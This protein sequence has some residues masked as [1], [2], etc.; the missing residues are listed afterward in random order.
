MKRNR[1]NN[2]TLKQLFLAVPASAL[3]LGSSQ[4]QT[5]VGINFAGGA[6]AAYASYN[7]MLYAQYFS[8]FPVTA[9]AFG[10]SPTNWTTTTGSSVGIPYN[11]GASGTVIAGPAASLTVNWT[12]VDCWG[13]DTGLTD[14][15]TNASG[16][17]VPPPGNDQVTWGILDNQGWTI[18][19]S[20]LNATFPNGYVIQC[21]GAGKVTGTSLVNFSDNSGYAASLGFDPLYTVDNQAIGLQT[22]TP[23]LTSDPITFSSDSRSM[24]DGNCAVAGFVVTDVPVVTLTSPA[25]TLI[26]PGAPFVLS[27]TAIGIGNLSYQWQQA[28]TNIP[29]ATSANYTNSSGAPSVA[30]DYQVVVTSSSFP[31]SPATGAVVVVTLH[32]AATVTWD[33]NTM[34]SGT[35]P[36][37]GSGTWS[38]TDT[39]WWNGSEDTY[40][41]VNDSAVFGAGGTGAYTVTLG[42]SVTA[43]AVTFNSGN[44]T[45]TNTSG[46]TLNL[47]G[48]QE[49]TANVGA[50]IAAPL[51]TGT[52][53]FLKA[54]AGALVISS[55]GLTCGQTFVNAGT[56][57]VLAKSGG[58]SPY[59]VTNGATLQIGYTTGGGYANTAMEIYGDGTNA[60]TGLYLAGGTTYNVS[61]TTTLLGGPTTIR[62][63]GSGLAAF[64]IFDI[65]DTGIYCT[66]AA[67]GSMIESNIQMVSDGYGM[68]VQADPGANTATGDLVINGPLNVD[69]NNGVYGLLKRGNGSLLLNTAASLNNCCLQVL[70][71]SAICGTD[72]CIGTNAILEVSA[73]ATLYINAT[74]QTVA[75]LLTPPTGTT[76]FSPA[77]LG[78]LVMSINK[79]GTPSS[80]LL[81]ESDGNSMVLAGSLTV[82]NVGP[83]VALGDTF[84]LLNSSGGFSGGFTSVSLPT[85]ANGLGWSN[86]LAVD[87]TITVVMGG[88]PTFV[89]NLTGT[90]NYG[91]VGGSSTLTIGAAGDPTLH[92][93]WIQN[94]TTPV[95]SNSPILT[96]APLTLADSGYYYV[97]VTNGYGSA[98]S[99]TNYL[100]VVPT[101]GYDA[102]V[103]AA[104]PVAFWPL[105]ESSG[106]TAY[107]YW[108]GY[109][110]TY[111]GG[112]TLDQITN[113]A[114]GE[115][116]A[117]FDG[118]SGYALTP[119]DAAL[120]PPV[121]S[122]EAWVNPLNVPASEFCVLSCGQFASSGRSGWLIYQF[123]GYWNFRTYYDNTT[124]TAVNLN[125]VSVPLIESW[126]HLAVT[127]DGTTARLYVNGVLEGSQVPTTTPNYVPGASGGFCIGARA[128]VSFYWG[129]AVSDVAFYNRALTALEIA[130]HAQNQP[131]LSI[132]PSGK[133]VVLSWPAG[134]VATVQ[135]SPS[136]TGTFTNVPGATSSPW[137]NTVSGQSMFFRLKF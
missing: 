41:Y 115:A 50:T 47:Q 8:G 20:G 65:H 71:G 22:P 126:T 104:G 88:G 110:A 40:L 114:T 66:A 23:T 83:A 58:D 129:G 97:V 108:S 90:T 36:Q 109:D 28:G 99:E 24:D 53:T 18:S 130:S 93:Q 73:G 94:G 101:S 3:M 17:T 51:S 79:G 54:G 95:G 134:Y 37:D 105:N 5:T 76:P 120:N 38:T 43:N 4:G 60:T 11:Y 15:A 125:G 49:I 35:H 67:S 44:Y 29:G 14:G 123:P 127:W 46:Q 13:T 136:L 59:V 132:T 118:A 133:N 52:N 57:Q 19:M 111:I 86:N 72:G 87:G 64:G 12:S 84:T 128:D 55:G 10:V 124:A 85:L 119:Y 98:Q 62:Q 70:A 7:G 39:N 68:A 75:N 122:A 121:F 45:I 61:G 21:I 30:G 26:S 80:G 27:S 82:T 2:K 131:L 113:P 34:A 63:F 137:T 32:T 96:L 6:Y 102:L 48:A 112:Y 116:G 91:Y 100:M 107:D 103:A 117:Q 106:T 69:A 33:T 77:L 25:S 9:A 16:M 31:S 135:A 56:L 1:F 92:Y 81:T 78:T 42:S 89:T 74:S